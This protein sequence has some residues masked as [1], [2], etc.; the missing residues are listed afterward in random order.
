MPAAPAFSILASASAS[1]ADPPGSS[2]L[3]AAVAWLQDTLLGSVATMVAVIAVA[4]VGFSMLNGRVSV[5]HGVTV[6]LGC[7]VLFGASAIAAGIRAFVGGDDT[8]T[9]AAAPP[10]AVPEL[11]PPPPAASDPYA[12]ASVPNR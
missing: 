2:V 6:V 7:F 9:Y 8:E 10:P 4:A 3:V 12:G 5:R 11:P 1:L